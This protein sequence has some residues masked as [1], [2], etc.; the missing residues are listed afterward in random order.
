MWELQIQTPG[1]EFTDNYIEE[2]S[3]TDYSH[4]IEQYPKYRW[5]YNDSL[6]Y[7]GTPS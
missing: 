3:Y 4:E 7:S 1:G 5:F 2:H 6:Q